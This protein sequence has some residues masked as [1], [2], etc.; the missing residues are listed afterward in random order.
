MV[1]GRCTVS[2]AGAEVGAAVE[3]GIGGVGQG[4]YRSLLQPAPNWVRLQGGTPKSVNSKGTKVNV[5]SR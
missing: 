5:R 3:E 1:Q 2:A 4:S